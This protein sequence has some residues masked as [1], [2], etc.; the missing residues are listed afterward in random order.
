[1]YQFTQFNLTQLAPYLLRTCS[2]L[3][4]FKTS[5]NF[6][7]VILCFIRGGCRQNLAA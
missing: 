7:D 5:C 4:P 6:A 3:R 1:M 2:D